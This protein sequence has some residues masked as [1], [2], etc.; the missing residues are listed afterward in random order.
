MARTG[1]GWDLTGIERRWRAVDDL[2]NKLIFGGV[3]TGWVDD[4]AGTPGRPSTVAGRRR[5]HGQG[6]DAPTD[7]G[8]PDD[9]RR[10][11]RASRRPDESDTRVEA[12]AACSCLEHPS[13]ASVRCAD[14]AHYV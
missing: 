12:D 2:E 7:D 14:N 8:T 1:E 10:P 5:A 4:P 13:R 6:D 9:T 3:D 11:S